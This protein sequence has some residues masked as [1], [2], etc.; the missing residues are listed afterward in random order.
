MLSWM[1]IGC[2]EPEGHYYM[3]YSTMYRWELE[4]CYRC[5]N[6]MAIAPFWF[7]TEHCYT[8]LMP[9]W[10]SME[11]CYT[12]LM[13]FWF[14]MEHCYTA[15]IPFWFSMEHCYTTL[16]PFWFSTEHCYTMLMPFWFSIIKLLICWSLESCFL[17]FKCLKFFLLGGKV[18]CILY[19]YYVYDLL[20]L[21]N[22]PKLFF[23]LEKN[24]S[25]IMGC[26]N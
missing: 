11:H 20:L 16:M 10:F 13:P 15:L 12:T 23:F 4:G 26:I 1:H 6:S 25:T 2:W 24:I 22:L 8:T 19:T 21:R 5:T 18:L 14:S 3:Y 17:F 7:S 9:F